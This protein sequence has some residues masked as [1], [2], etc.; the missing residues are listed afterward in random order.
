MAKKK[1]S[2]K[3]SMN[4][5]QK[6]E[7]GVGL[8]AAAVAAA[9][10]YFLYGSKNAAQNRQKVKSWTLKAKA[11]ILERLEEV[12]EISWDDYQD[13]V[14]QVAA[15][16]AQVKNASKADIKAFREEMLAQWKNLEKVGKPKKKPAGKKTAKKTAKKSAKKAS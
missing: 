7:I 14:E 6:F 5:T 3:D 9:G 13:L 11:E 16:Y 4:T 12:K 8:T 15:S 1:Q 10:A 2:N